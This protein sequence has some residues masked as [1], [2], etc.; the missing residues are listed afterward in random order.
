MRRSKEETSPVDEIN[1]EAFT[2]AVCT[3][4]LCINKPANRLDRGEEVILHWHW[5]CLKV[6]RR[7]NFRTQRV[8]V[9]REVG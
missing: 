2:S 5:F 1:F 8:E 3:S 7:E 4:L 9:E 6:I